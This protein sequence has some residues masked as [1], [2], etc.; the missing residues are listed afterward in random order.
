MIRIFYGDD[1]V[2]A[3]QEIKKILGED[4]EVLE[5]AEMAVEDLP[6]VFMGAS[7]FA[8]ERRI[9]IRDLNTNRV[10][11]DE[12]PKYFTTKHEVVI[13]ESKVDKRAT[14]Y[15]EL[16]DKI[17]YREFRLP[18]NV[19]FRVVFDIYRVA[20]CDGKR[21]VALLEQIKMG[22]D[23]I[24]FTGLMAS[25]ALKDF[26]SK[27][28]AREKRVLKELAK[29]DIEMKTTKIDPWLLV[30]SFLIRLETL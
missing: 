24:K 28:G 3:K 8:S 11:Y 23:P 14:V 16:K 10:V 2:R 20:K 12:L 5:G 17:E 26:A 25:Q 19:D 1:R 9:L 30:E 15:K 13:L 18:E 4:Y 27:G 7:L 21:A 29:I 6:S 22:E